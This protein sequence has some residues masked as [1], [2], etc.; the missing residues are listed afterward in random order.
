MASLYA[1]RR[2]KI[3]VQPSADSLASEQP[4]LSGE[5]DPAGL[6]LPGYEVGSL[7]YRSLGRAVYRARRLEDGAAVAVETLDAEYPE[8]QQVARIRREGYIALQLDRVEGVRK[9]HAM[10]PHGSGNLALVGELY[11]TTLD[12]HLSKLSLIHI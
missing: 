7:L 12:A 3:M 2:S 10:L 1:I 8:R 11:E 5:A 4:G 6:Q 9:V